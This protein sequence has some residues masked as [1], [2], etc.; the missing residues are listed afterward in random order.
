MTADDR[1]FVDTNVLVHA[2]VAA[3]P[4]H[5]VAYDALAA[6]RTTPASLWLTRQVLREYL[7]VLTRPQ[8]FTLPALD[9]VLSDATFLEEQFRMA[10]E[11]PVVTAHLLRLMRNVPVGG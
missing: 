10:D 4:L 9:T 1:I 7:A 2:N 5:R 8:A 3:A 11:T 6:L